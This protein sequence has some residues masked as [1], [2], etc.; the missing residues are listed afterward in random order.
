MNKTL[1]NLLN[2]AEDTASSAVRG[3]SQGWSDTAQILPTI[4]GG[5]ANTGIN[6]L[7]AVGKP[8]AK[9]IDYISP[10]FS[11]SRAAR[12]DYAKEGITRLTGTIAKA[13]RNHNRLTHDLWK[14]R[15]GYDAETVYA[16]TRVIPY[17][18]TIRPALNT[19]S[20]L[21][22][23][24][25]YSKLPKATGILGKARNILAARTTQ[26]VGTGLAFVAPAIDAGFGLSHVNPTD[27]NLVRKIKETSA[28]VVPL[29]GMVM[30]P[31][32]AANYIYRHSPAMADAYRRM[33][34]RTALNQINSTSVY[35]AI[36]SSETML[37]DL[38]ALYKDKHFLASGDNLQAL[39]R[40]VDDTINSLKNLKP[41]DNNSDLLVNFAVNDLKNY[42][43]KDAVNE[44]YL[45]NV[46]KMLRTTD[47]EE[48]DSSVLDIIKKGPQNKIL[49]YMW[50]QPT[51]S[52]ELTKSKEVGKK[53]LDKV[54]NILYNDNK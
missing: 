40:H 41:S 28:N 22:N 48:W 17:I 5:M 32:H 35:D 53:I 42:W 26:R 39:K 51:E 18:S 30:N 38:K 23:L 14:P 34:T 11:K 9:G 44:Y 19:F 52:L 27:S 37:N 50:L 2:R 8:L 12:Y 6:I 46:L 3:M 54:K 25:I 10:G 47:P 7:K 13:F 16:A 15:H 49:R 33:F 21:T 4:Y 24:S 31:A 45:A 20:P 29:T 1:K 36:D 43:N